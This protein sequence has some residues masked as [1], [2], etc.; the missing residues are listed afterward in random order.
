MIP[1][2]DVFLA[3]IQMEEIIGLNMRIISIRRD[4]QACFHAASNS[5]TLLDGASIEPITGA[6]RVCVDFHGAMAGAV[7]RMLIAARALRYNA[8]PRS[9][10]VAFL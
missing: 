1:C 10:H 9:R 7:N 5:R 6:N 8:N 2:S 3:V 4:L